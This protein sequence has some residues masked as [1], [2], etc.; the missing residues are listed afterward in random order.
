MSAFRF[1]YN[2]RIVGQLTVAG[3]RHEPIEIY[4]TSK[5]LTPTE[6]RAIT[7]GFGPE[8]DLGAEFLIR[9]HWT[10]GGRH[11]PLRTGP[12]RDTLS[13]SWKDRD[14]LENAGHAPEYKAAP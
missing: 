6:Y 5:V 2:A 12:E 3:I 13:L 11:L 14:R 8:W 7:A 9:G 4:R 10:L 1:P